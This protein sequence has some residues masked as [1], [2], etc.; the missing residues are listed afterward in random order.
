MGFQGLLSTLFPQFQIGG[1][2][3][4]VVV[5]DVVAVVVVIIVVEFPR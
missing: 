4:V 5:A 3:V 1:S 2:V